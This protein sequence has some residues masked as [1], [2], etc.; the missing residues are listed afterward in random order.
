MGTDIHGYIEVKLNLDGMF[1]EN[2]Q[3]AVDL[4]WLYDGQDT[5]AFGCFL[6]SETMPAFVLLRRDVACHST[7]LL[8]SN[9]SRGM[10]TWRP[11]ITEELGL[12]GVIS[13]RLIGKRKQNMLMGA[14]TGTDVMNRGSSFTKEN[15]QG[16]GGSLKWSDMIS[17]S[18]IRNRCGTWA[19]LSTRTKE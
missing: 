19:M 15:Q 5:D 12:A 18:T 9:G 3:A 13:N 14:F 2:W 7:F 17:V 1:E 6:G 11:P 16:A 4:F 10:G 8:R